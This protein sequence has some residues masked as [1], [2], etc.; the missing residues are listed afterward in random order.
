MRCGKDREGGA[1]SMSN[2]GLYQKMTTAAKKVGGP[3]PFIGAIAVAGYVAFRTVEAGVKITAKAVRKHLPLKETIALD[4][5]IVHTAGE[6]NEGVKFSVG[7]QFRILEIDE[8]AVLI[9]K[10]GDKNNPYFVSAE[11]LCSL[12]NFDVQW[13]EQV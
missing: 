1:Y 8:D 2:L 12:S 5:Y 6:S 9:E 13:K 3:I 11:L 4:T 10:I 7:E